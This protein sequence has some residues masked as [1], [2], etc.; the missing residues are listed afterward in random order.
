[1]VEFNTTKEEDE[2]INN[3]VKRVHTLH[4]GQFDR[5]TISMDITACHCNGTKLDLEKLLNFDDFNFNHDIF[6]INYH[7]DRNTGKLKNFFLPRCT[8]N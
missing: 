5:T 4:P 1:M 7:I 2:L 6:G 8:K 3:I